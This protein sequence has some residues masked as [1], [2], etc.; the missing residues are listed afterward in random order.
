MISLSRYI[1]YNHYHPFLFV[2]DLSLFPMIP[3]THVSLHH[4]PVS[5]IVS[6]RQKCLDNVYDFITISQRPDANPL[7]TNLAML[8]LG[9][10]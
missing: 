5:I 2:L 9:F 4:V 8:Y 1:R 7:R 6:D 3:Q 10:D